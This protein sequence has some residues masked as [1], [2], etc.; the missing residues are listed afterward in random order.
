M[1]ETVCVKDVWPYSSAQKP[2]KGLRWTTRLRLQPDRKRPFTVVPVRLQ[3]GLVPS[4]THHP[5]R[6]YSIGLLKSQHKLAAYMPT[7]AQFV[8]LSHVFEREDGINVRF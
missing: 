4:P 2:R 6:F 7:N 1:Q 3:L 5:H 8:G